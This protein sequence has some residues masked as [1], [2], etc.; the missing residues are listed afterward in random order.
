MILRHDY[1]SIDL[2]YV[3]GNL[4]VSGQISGDYAKSAKQSTINYGDRFLYARESPDVRYVKEGDARLTNGE[5]RIDVDPIFLECIEPHTPDSRWYITLTP[6]GKAILY[7]DEIGDD[8]FIVKDYNDNANGIEFT[9]SL[10]A[11]RKDYANINLMEAI[12]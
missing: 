12:D 5:A 4:H 3:A 2:H 6:Y 11:T 7:V 10:S 8:Y 1:Q 9:W